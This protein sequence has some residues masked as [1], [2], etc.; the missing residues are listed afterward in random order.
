MICQSQIDDKAQ[1][2][3]NQKSPMRSV[4][5][6]QDCQI[7]Y[8]K[9]LQRLIEGEDNLETK[10]MVDNRKWNEHSTNLIKVKLWTKSFVVFLQLKTEQQSEEEIQ[11][12]IAQSDNDNVAS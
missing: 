9:R 11:G 5:K 2:P 4:S 3:I 10:H 6:G 12:I 7:A 1:T 8:C